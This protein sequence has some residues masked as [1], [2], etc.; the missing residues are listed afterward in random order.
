[1]ATTIETNFSV[2]LKDDLPHLSNGTGAE[3]RVVRALRPR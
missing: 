3:G 2:V 1:M